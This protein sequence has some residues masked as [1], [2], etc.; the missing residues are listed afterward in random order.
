MIMKAHRIEHET[1]IQGA[2]KDTDEFAK[3]EQIRDALVAHLRNPPTLAA[4]NEANQ[5]GK[6]SQDVQKLVTPFAESLGFKS[7]KRG[8]FDSYENT[9]LRPDYYLALYDTGIIFEV[10]RG[11]TTTNN[12]DL[13]D[14]WKCHICEHAHYLVLMV[15]MELRHNNGPKNK[16]KKEYSKVV[17]RLGSFFTAD[18]YT[19]VRGVVI[20]GY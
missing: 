7:E 15:P 10:E 12:N 2:Y 13:L 6:K 4:I 9:G 1:F 18:T 8:L 19:N 11:Q 5:P 3:V 14:L 20:L 16:P 17:K